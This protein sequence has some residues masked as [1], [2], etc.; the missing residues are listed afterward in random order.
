MDIHFEKKYIKYKI[1]YFKLKQLL[2]NGKKKKKEKT[3]FDCGAPDCRRGDLTC[4]KYSKPQEE[5]E[6]E[7]QARI[8]AMTETDRRK[9]LAERRYIEQFTLAFETNNFEPINQLVFDLERDLPNEFVIK[10]KI[11]SI[12]KSIYDKKKYNLDKNAAG[13]YTKESLDNKWNRYWGLSKIEL[14]KEYKITDWNTITDSSGMEI[15]DQRRRNEETKKDLSHYDKHIRQIM[16]TWSD[17]WFSTWTPEYIE[18]LGKLPNLYHLLEYIIDNTFLQITLWYRNP[19]DD[20]FKLTASTEARPTLQFIFGFGNE[21]P[22]YLKTIIVKKIGTKEANP[23]THQQLL[24][25]ELFKKKLLK[26]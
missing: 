11:T 9:A 22:D 19:T 24:L 7:E 5:I 6:G 13:L 10:K 15:D 12:L 18:S 16:H 17:L 26:E 8:D 1:K 2:G 21:K 25:S 3:C 4:P 20:G 23:N 14:E